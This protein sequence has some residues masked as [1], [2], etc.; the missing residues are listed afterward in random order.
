MPLSF[1]SQS[2]LHKYL[3]YLVEMVLLEYSLLLKSIKNNHIYLI[4]FVHLTPQASKRLGT[5]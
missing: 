1:R 4:F 3:F 5:T 2:D